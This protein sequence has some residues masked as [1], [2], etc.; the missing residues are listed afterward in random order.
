MVKFVIGTQV[1][2]EEDLLRIVSLLSLPLGLA[3]LFFKKINKTTEN[4][5]SL[6]LKIS[7]LYEI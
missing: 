7:Q 2:E 3:H 1:A 5:E 6:F 4:F